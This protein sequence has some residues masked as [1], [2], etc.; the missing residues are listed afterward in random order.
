MTKLVILPC[1]SI[2][3][4]GPTLGDSRQEW[5]L[6]SF[7]VEGNDHLSFK[8]H[9]TRSLDYL[10]SDPD[11]YLV[12]SGGQ[13]KRE[14]GPVSESLSYYLLAQALLKE[15]SI[16]LNNRITTEEFAR[17][18]FENVIFLICRY[19]EIFGKYPDSI[20]IIGF[21]F[22]RIRFLD[23]HM[24]ALKWPSSNVEY[25]GNLPNPDLVRD[26]RQ[27]YFEDLEASE[28]KH[29][30]EHFKADKFGTKSPLIEKKLSR[31]PF[32]RSH[33]YEISNPLLAPFLRAIRNRTQEEDDKIMLKLEGAPWIQ[34]K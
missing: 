28:F 5:S 19:Y 25:I 24:Q 12:I 32:S 29:A 14:L 18:S 21:E 13:T 9:I 34:G 15:E 17:D 22:K 11:A 20:T 8:E 10:R 4:P 30:V 6:A 3:K 2:W 27:K 1:H 33:G 7:Q 16:E 23:Y 31:N 26:Q